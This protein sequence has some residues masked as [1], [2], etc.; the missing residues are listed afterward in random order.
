MCPA[1]IQ[2]SIG[3]HAKHEGIHDHNHDLS[4]AVKRK[5]RNN[6]AGQKKEADALREEYMQK[7]MAHQKALDAM[8]HGFGWAFEKFNTDVKPEAAL[9]QLYN[10]LSVKK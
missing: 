3:R 9:A 2:S 1:C 6:Q 7:F 5:P 4:F 8:A 10:V